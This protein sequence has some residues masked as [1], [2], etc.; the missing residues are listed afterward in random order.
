MRKDMTNLHDC[1]NL[2]KVTVKRR[3]KISAEIKLN[4][5]EVIVSSLL[6]S[7]QNSA[8]GRDLYHNCQPT[9]FKYKLR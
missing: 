2:I 3:N 4:P 9:L 7:F 8:V 6:I 1:E 5:T